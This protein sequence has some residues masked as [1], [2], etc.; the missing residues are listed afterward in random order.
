MLYFVECSYTDPKSEQEWNEFI[1]RRDTDERALL[2]NMP[3]WRFSG[4]GAE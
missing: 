1:L 4:N 2:P 3:D